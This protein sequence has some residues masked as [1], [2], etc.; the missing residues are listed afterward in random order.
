MKLEVSLWAWFVYKG[1]WTRQLT[2]PSL[3]PGDK[4]RLVTSKIWTYQE[5][6]A[7][8]MKISSCKEGNGPASL[9]WQGWKRK[10]TQAR[11][12]NN[13]L[14]YWYILKKGKSVVKFTVLDI[15]VLKCFLC[16]KPLLK[17]GGERLRAI[18]KA[19]LVCRIIDIEQFNHSERFDI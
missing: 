9:F 3:L 10:E 4:M 18:C 12:M 6:V 19:V 17:R 13:I 8:A 15:I 16:W 2:A 7:R 1:W 11:H 5:L 14:C